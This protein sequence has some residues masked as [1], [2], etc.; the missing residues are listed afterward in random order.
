[1]NLAV[2]G[3]FNLSRLGLGLWVTSGVND[4]AQGVS[5]NL[6]FGPFSISIAVLRAVPAKPKAKHVPGRD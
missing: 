2:K 6:M 1:M 4:K 3:E 5:V